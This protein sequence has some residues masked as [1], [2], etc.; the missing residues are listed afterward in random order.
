MLNQE[1]KELCWQVLAKYGIKYQRNMVAEESAELVQATCKL[2]R[3]GESEKDHYIEE[4]VDT[5]V[6][7]QEMLL[8]DGITMDEVNNRAKPKLIKALKGGKE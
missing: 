1:N 3:Y 4:L 5:I 2:F 8:A 7:I 6:V